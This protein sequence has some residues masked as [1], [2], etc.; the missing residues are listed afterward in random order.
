MI[1]QEYKV[2]LPHATIGSAFKL[3]VMELSKKSKVVLLIDEYDKPLVDHI[4]NPSLIEE[5]RKIL[6]SFY[7]TVKSLDVYWRAIFITGVSK[8][9]KTSLF[10]G[11]NNLKDLTFDPIAAELF[12]YT[13]EDLITY[14]SSDIDNLAH[15]LGK[16]REEILEDMKTWY[17]GYRFS[18]DMQ[19]PLMYNPLSVVACLDSKEFANYWFNTGNP[20]FLIALLRL[21][22]VES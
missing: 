4:G 12:G 2:T 21:K 10:S 9:S 6:N 1:A 3:L 8:F 20:G 14:F 16:T 17:D 18:K 22:G 11:L 19:K 5:N 13:H 7:T 15:H